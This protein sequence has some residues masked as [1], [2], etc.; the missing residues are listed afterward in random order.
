M[1]EI[2]FYIFLKQA[3]NACRDMLRQCKCDPTKCTGPGPAPPPSRR[4]RPHYDRLLLPI[5]NNEAKRRQVA[6]STCIRD[7]HGTGDVVSAPFCAAC[8]ASFPPSQHAARFQHALLCCPLS[9]PSPCTNAAPEV[10][11]ISRALLRTLPRLLNSEHTSSWS[12]WK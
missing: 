2:I 4:I 8:A 6:P 1:N 9:G 12:A 3:G 5:P 7:G 11:F 10:F